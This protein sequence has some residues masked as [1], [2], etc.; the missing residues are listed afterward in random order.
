M[1]DSANRPNTTADRCP[2]N[3][4]PNIK[5][6]LKTEIDLRFCFAPLLVVSGFGLLV[7]SYL[8]LTEQLVIN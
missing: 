3:Y 1:K 7:W 8:L 5:Q 4:S 6:N 2:L